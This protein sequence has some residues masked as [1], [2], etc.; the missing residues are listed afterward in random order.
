[1]SLLV[2]ATMPVTP[3]S[4]AGYISGSTLTVSTGGNQRHATAARIT[5]RVFQSLRRLRRSKAHVDDVDA[6]VGSV[7]DRFVDVRNLCASTVVEHA[8]RPD[9]RF[10]SNHAKQARHSGSMTI[11]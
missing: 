3:E 2:T 5:D 8:Y 9:R 6:V 1:M 4:C 11:T 10:R 7:N